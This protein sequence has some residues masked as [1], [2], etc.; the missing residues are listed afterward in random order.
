MINKNKLN[1]SIS[2]FFSL[3]PLLIIFI[4]LF[5]YIFN[6]FYFTLQLLTFKGYNIGVFI[7]LL[8]FQNEMV[9]YVNDLIMALYFLLTG[10]A[11]F[12]FHFG[13]IV[14]G[15]YTAPESKFDL[16]ETA[17]SHKI[18]Y[19]PL[20]IFDFIIVIFGFILSFLQYILYFITGAPLKFLLTIW[21]IWPII[22]IFFLIPELLGIL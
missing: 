15:F 13:L 16:P 12:A 10:F 21:I 1:K 18:E 2:H 20:G 11:F 5:F 19:T 6:Y 14:N 22:M 17:K 9:N 3:S 8:N 4:L 7:H